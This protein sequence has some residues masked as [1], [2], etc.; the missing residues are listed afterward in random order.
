MKILEKQTFLVDAN[1]DDFYVCITIV[2]QGKDY[3]GYI[4][5]PPKKQNMAYVREIT[6]SLATAGARKI[7]ELL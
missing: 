2:Y 1:P 6:S 5:I 7:K 3:R 4:L